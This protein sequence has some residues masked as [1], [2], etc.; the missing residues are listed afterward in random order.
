MAATP[1][2]IKY[3]FEPRGVAI[4]GASQNPKKIGYKITDNIV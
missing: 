3:L 2:D 1:P 4:I